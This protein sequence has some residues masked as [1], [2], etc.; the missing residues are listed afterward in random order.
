MFT[1]EYCGYHTHNPHYDIIDRPS[2]SSS[3]LFLLVLSPMVFTF[4]DRPA[5]KAQPGACILYAPGYPQYYQAEREFFNSYVHFFAPAEAVQTYQIP[6]NCIFPP[7]CP[8]RLQSVPLWK[9]ALPQ[10]QPGEPLVSSASRPLIPQ[11]PL[12]RPRQAQLLSGV[13]SF[14]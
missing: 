10:S 12:P 11:P 14:S 8:T 7:P 13:Y 5:E 4:P 3:Y 9:R 1:V 2:G 6:E